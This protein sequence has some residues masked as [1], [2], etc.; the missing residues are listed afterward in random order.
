MTHF[1]RALRILSQYF[2]TQTISL[3]HPFIEKITIFKNRHIAQ[4]TFIPRLSLSAKR[5]YSC[6]FSLRITSKCT[7]ESNKTRVY[8]PSKGGLGQRDPLQSSS[9]RIKTSSESWISSNN[10]LA[11]KDRVFTV[12]PS[13]NTIPFP[14]PNFPP[15]TS[16]WYI[17]V[18][19][20]DL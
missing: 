16:L 12:T 15:V 3:K 14:W 13:G 17:G 10:G 9:R 19:K 1:L 4:N 2:L 7:H 18:E 20:A 8:S 6:K 11:H 5:K